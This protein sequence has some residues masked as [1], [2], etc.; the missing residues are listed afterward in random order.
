[1]TT[2]ND[3]PIRR[4]TIVSN[5]KK[6]DMFDIHGYGCRHSIKINP[7][8]IYGNARARSTEHVV[9]VAVENVSS[10]QWTEKHFRVMPCCANAPVV[11]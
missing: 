2:N 10:G 3:M 7:A 6:A 9:K 8:D 4:Y 5:P 1:M 11:K